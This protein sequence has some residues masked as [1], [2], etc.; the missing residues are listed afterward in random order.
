MV[1]A[2]RGTMESLRGGSALTGFTKLRL[3]DKLKLTAPP[4][5]LSE[6]LID[7]ICGTEKKKKK[8]GSWINEIDKSGK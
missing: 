4:M 1:V 3:W 2:A 7:P 8:T 5:G 6:I